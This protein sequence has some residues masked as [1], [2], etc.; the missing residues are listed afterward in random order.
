MIKSIILF[1]LLSVSAM[2]A[3]R[4]ITLAWDLSTDDAALGPTGGYRVYQATLSGQ[5]SAQPVATVAP[6]ISTAS[7]PLATT[8]KYFWIVRAFSGGVES[9]NSNEVSQSIGPA[10]PGNVRIII[11][12]RVSV[13]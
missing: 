11:D 13:K 9:V 6:G 3:D 8:G 4:T 10:S 1:L 5:Y 2:A 7:F 12:M